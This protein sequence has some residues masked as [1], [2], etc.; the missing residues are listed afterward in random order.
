MTPQ[1]IQLIRS[2]FALV[3]PIAPAVASLFYEQLFIADPSLR[4]LFKIDIQGQGARLMDM[5]GVAVG[6]LDRPQTLLPVLRQLGTRHVDYGVQVAHY[7]IV[8]RA[9]INTLQLGLGDAFD[10][11]T[12]AAWLAMYALVSATMIEGACE[13]VPAQRVRC[14]LPAS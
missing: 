14:A 9:L 7:A 13:A 3:S 5:I 12:R 8:G 10:S 6:L 4:R 2:S 11:D 1:H